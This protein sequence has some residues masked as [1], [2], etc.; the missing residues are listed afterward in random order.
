MPSPRPAY[1]T[2][3]VTLYQGDALALLRQL[4]SGSVH[5]CVT[6]P[7][8]FG[9]RDYGMA[10]QIGLEWTPDAYVARLVEV[11][12]EVRRVLHDT[13]T[14]WLNLGDSYATGGGK[15]GESPGGGP[16]GERWTGYRG[17]RPGSAKHAAGAMGPMTQPNRMPLPGLKPKD[18]I[19]IP[20]RVAFALQA[21]GWYLR[22]DVIWHKPNPMPESV[23]G[24]RW[25]RHRVQVVHGAVSRQ[26][27]LGGNGR[28]RH[29]HTIA[30]KPQPA[31]WIDCPGCR[32]CAP[33]DGYVLR[34]GSG[35]LT[36]A[37]EYVFLLT[38]TDTYF[39]DSEAVLEPCASGP[40]DIK[41]MLEQRDRITSRYRD[42]HDP[43]LAGGNGRIGRKRAVGSPAGRNR[44]S[45]WTLAT[46]P[47]KGSHFATFPPKLVEP[48]LLAG[49]S[50]HGCC[51]KCLAPWVR[52]VHRQ[53]APH[54]AN[55]RHSGRG[56][57]HFRPQ[58]S[59]RQHRPG[60]E[61]CVVTN[62]ETLGWRPTCPHDAPLMPCT[63]LDPFA[64]AATTGLVALQH[65][66]RFVG[67]ELNPSYLAQAI[68]RLTDAA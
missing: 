37:H 48:M 50:A 40:S 5:C 12:R 38:K 63:V 27:D 55:G 13:G 44:R 1:Q 57:G 36:K 3:D 51:A 33:H 20:W 49:T 18:L 19:G 29:G 6:S 68:T 17:T 22:S 47:Y 60:H 7:P 26:A 23:Q 41:K 32:T 24:W 35:R 15:V 53:T 28:E 30:D 62:S 8:Y 31:E 34:R 21:D 66:R 45:V 14:L 52:V 61:I 2:D 64:G 43:W 39:Y 16:Q 11:F 67:L 58:E 4:P 10:E 54:P 59:G 46:Q 65:G 42:A 25:E 56:A 9:L